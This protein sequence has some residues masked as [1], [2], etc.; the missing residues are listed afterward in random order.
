MTDVA[1]EPEAVGSGRYATIAMV[2]HWLIAFAIATQVSLAWR[3]KDLHTPEGF[4]LTQ[5]HKSIGV[6][7]LVLSLLR[8]AWRLMNPPPPLPLTMARWEKL[9]AQV[10]HV[11][12]YVIM[13]GMPLTGWIMVSASRIPVPTLLY[14]IVPWPN[15]PGMASLAPGAKH[16]WHSIGDNGHVWLSYGLY[17][18][19][20][21]HVGGALKHQLFSR[22]EPV[23]ARM[24]P[25]AVAGR[26][27]DWRLILILAGLLGA[28]AFGKLVVPPS[29]GMAPP[30]I[31]AS[32]QDA[33]QPA[34]GP[35]AGPPQA[36]IAP[37]AVAA[38][39]EPAPTG[40]VR[41]AVLP[42]STLGFATTWSG[43]GVQGRFRTWKADIVF[44][45]DAL[46]RS[47]VTVTI[48]LAS[49]ETGDAQR[50]AV[51]PSPDWFDTANHPKAVFTASRF[52][53]TGA[54][55]YL[56][57]GTLQLRGVTRPQ[58]L[59]FRLDIAGDQA[60]VRGSAGLD[61]TV[62]GVGQGDFKATDQI[63][64]KV[65]VTVG[66]KARRAAG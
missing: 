36:A 23:L 38:S 55:R 12:L 44:S 4:A 8:L 28:V 46:A 2:L 14:G 35:P 63:P 60:V 53:K 19:F 34:G 17:G 16:L 39:R 32:Q 9:L 5:L 15:V 3:M 33:D 37:A 40:P 56:A 43:Q 54:D 10:V 11:G 49:A 25:G 20:V 26:W 47:K 66:L 24:A 41:W 30:P 45:P 64:A 52:E 13:I 18:L 65:A 51:L 59:E 22:D 57:H 48:D 21:L 27:L 61:R 1:R 6:T 42:G 29:P 31:P 50:D 7:I 62:F 58:D